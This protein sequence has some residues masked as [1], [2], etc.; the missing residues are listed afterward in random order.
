[1]VTKAYEFSTEVTPDGKL[2]IPDAYAKDIPIG[3][4]VR[5]IVLVNEPETQE[6]QEKFLSLER[7]IAEIKNTPS[8][9]TNILPASGLLAE[10]L[11]NS[12]G[13]PDPSFDVAAWNNA[14]DKVENEMEATETAN[15]QAEADI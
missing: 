11:A 5:V 10:H 2:L 14:W 6:A 1:M 13:E 8:N 4:A 12:P 9:P 15:E 3:D 7:I